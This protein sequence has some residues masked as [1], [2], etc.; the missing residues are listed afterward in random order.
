MREFV[1]NKNDADQRVDKYLSKSL[2]RLP[3]SLMY[4]YIRNKKIKVNRQRCEISQR[5]NVGDTI[6]MYISEE[7]FD[8]QLDTS[9]M[10]ASKLQNVV[11]EDDHLLIVNK[12]AN[13]LVHSDEADQTDTLI[14]RILKYLVEHKAY[15]PVSEKSFMPALCHRID[16]NTEGLVI[17]AKSAEALR[18]MNEKIREREIEKHYLCIVEGELYGS[19]TLVHYYRKDE[20]QNKA[21]LAQK[22]SAGMSEVRLSYRSLVVKHGY[23]LLDIDLLTGKSHQIRAQ[24]S[25]I[26][27]PLVNDVKYHGKAMKKLEGH[28]LCAYKLCFAFKSDAGCLNYLKNK[29]IQIV[30]PALLKLFEQL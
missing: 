11:Y 30:E 25:F 5:L 16:R 9:F 4:K 23:S 7:F 15:D 21:Y 3:K 20:Q 27:H 6:Q 29:E 13:L 2:K 1:V 17:A 8:E 19:G 10:Q 12:P 14:N 18:M 22:P 28:A 26:G 24:L